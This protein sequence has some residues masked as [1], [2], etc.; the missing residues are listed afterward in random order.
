MS[1]ES[2]TVPSVADKARILRVWNPGFL[3]ILA[4]PLASPRH[5]SM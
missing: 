2:S 1:R 4:A 3:W 5:A